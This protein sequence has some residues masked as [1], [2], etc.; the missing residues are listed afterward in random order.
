LL[1]LT[2]RSSSLKSDILSAL[3]CFKLV[4]FCF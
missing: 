4:S 1:A 3:P 2:D